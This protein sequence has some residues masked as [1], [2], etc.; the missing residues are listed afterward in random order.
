MSYGHVD[1]V[2]GFW[3]RTD[4]HSWSRVQ[5]SNKNTPDNSLSTI[6]HDS[7]V[8]FTIIEKA[9]LTL[10]Y[11][12]TEVQNSHCVYKSGTPP[13]GK[14]KAK[15]S[16]YVTH[17]HVPNIATRSRR[18]ADIWGSALGKD[19]GYRDWESCLL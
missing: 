10:A 8:N 12:M 19:R 5:D 14:F 7:V 15:Q 3:T 4:T 16:T 9:S 18:E 11:S 17:P 13:G 6:S 1:S 2:C